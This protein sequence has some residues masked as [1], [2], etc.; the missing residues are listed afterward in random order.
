MQ[1][2]IEAIDELRK[3]IE[4]VAERIVTRINSNLSIFLEVVDLEYGIPKPE[5]NRKTSRTKYNSISPAM[6]IVIC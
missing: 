1:N 5:K 3:Q 2:E 4:T 6:A